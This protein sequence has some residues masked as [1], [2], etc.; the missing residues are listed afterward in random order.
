MLAAF[1]LAATTPATPASVDADLRCLAV[2]TMALGSGAAEAQRQ[3][4]IVAAMY[5]VG[6]IDAARPGFD[7][8]KEL[9]DLLTDPATIRSLAA[10]AARCGAVLQERGQVLQSVGEKLQQRGKAQR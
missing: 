1:L 2:A 4:L 7:Y 9:G 8:E 5:F 6:R 3:G 10:D